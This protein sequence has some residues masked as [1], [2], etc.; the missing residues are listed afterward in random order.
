VSAGLYGKTLFL[1]KQ[2]MRREALDLIVDPED[3]FGT[4]HAVNLNRVS[5]E[6]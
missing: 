5:G 1:E 3:T 6:R 4:G 2:D